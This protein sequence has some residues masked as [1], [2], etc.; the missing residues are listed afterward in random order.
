MTRPYL[1]LT[2]AGLM[3]TVFLA[4]PL[5]LLVRFSLYAPGRG[6]YAPGTWTPRAYADLAADPTFRSIL[7][8]TLLAAAGITVLTLLLAYPLA[9]FIHHLPPRSQAVAV[10]L[11]LVPKLANVLVLVYGLQLV[12]S[13]FQ[14]VMLHRNLFG[15]V[16]G[17]TYLLLPYAI[18]LVLLGL[19][20]VDPA[21]VAAARG[22]G[23]T[24]WQAFR[25]VTL[26]LSLPGLLAALQLTQLW[27]LAAVLGPLILGGPDQTTLGVEVQRQA[28]ELNHWPRAAATA[29]VLGTLLLLAAVVTGWRPPEDA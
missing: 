1:L 23:A 2:P 25:R 26:P 14:P 10:A 28:F 15:T 8:F 20:R 24:R 21:L 29:V 11:V 18:L 7:T 27:S 9:L 16:A 12:L 17:E 22:L 6:F 4:G 13:S 5:A 3:L 19:R